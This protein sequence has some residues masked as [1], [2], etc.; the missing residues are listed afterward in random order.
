GHRSLEKSDMP[1]GEEE[2]HAAG[3]TAI[4]LVDFVVRVPWP[5]PP[6]GVPEDHAGAAL[7]PRIADAVVVH[8]EE[9]GI[10]DR[11]CPGR[12]AEQV[13]P[14]ADGDRLGG[15]VGDGAEPDVP[16]TEEDAITV[17]AGI[18]RPVNTDVIRRGHLSDALRRHAASVPYHRPPRLRDTIRRA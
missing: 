3:M 8:W 15:A 11:S 7:G 5:E 12:C 1:V 13:G 10:G 9:D 4:E 16:V 2:I 14:V 6:T 17:D 18:P